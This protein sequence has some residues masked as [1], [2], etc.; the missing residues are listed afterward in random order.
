M[1]NLR[2]K[3]AQ[4]IAPK[5][6]LVILESL[7]PKGFGEAGFT[8]ITYRGMPLIDPEKPTATEYIEN[9]TSSDLTSSDL[10][11][12]T[13]KQLVEDKEDDKA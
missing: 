7:L 3:L 1:K 4:W 8:A 2:L 5:G 6:F 9:L 12:Q 13:R 10:W 11:R